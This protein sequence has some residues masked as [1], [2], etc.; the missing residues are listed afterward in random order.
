MAG[1][2]RPSLCGAR[3]VGIQLSP[4]RSPKDGA[5]ASG[6]ATTAGSMTPRLRRSGSGVSAASHTLWVRQPGRY[7]GSPMT[8]RSPYLEEI[9][10]LDPVDD[11]TR[12]TQLVVCYEF[13]FDT[14][15]SL[16]MAFFRT[17]AIPEIGE[18]LDSTQEF[19]RRAQR[20]YDDTDLIVSTLVEDGY[21]SETGRRALRRMNQI[22]GRFP[23][24]NDD[25]LYVLS[26]FVFEP[27]RWTDRFG[28]RRMVENERLGIFHCWREI[29][30]RMG[31][32]DIPE[33]Y[34]DFERF[35][36]EYERERFRYSDGGHRVAVATRDMFLRW[37]PGLPRALGE[38]AIYAVLDDALLDALGFPRPTAL[39]RRAVEA[40]LRLRGRALRLFPPRRS[41]RLRTA[42]R[43][44][45]YPRGWRIDELG[46]A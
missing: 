2:E 12:I 29:G 40:A 16:E 10:R 41:P 13:P 30:R 34:E 42:G 7:D 5:I 39:E 35:N 36:V 33:R 6:I 45:S 3:G 19:A 15:R 43:R 14:T 26:N 31:I 23:I 28:W 17:Y 38:R 37:F 18:R 21:D 22:H 27:V 9:L 25:F 24:A 20:R 32:T 1:G 44:R 4:K 11:H 46:P 8:R